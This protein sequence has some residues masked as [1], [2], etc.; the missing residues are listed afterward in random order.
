MNWYIIVPF[1]VAIIILLIYLIKKN[2]KDEK[3][4]EAFSNKD[5]PKKIEEDEIENS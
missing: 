4:Y 1:G 3:A 2:Q 5:Y